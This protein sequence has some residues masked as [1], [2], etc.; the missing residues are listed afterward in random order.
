MRVVVRY[1]RLGDVYIFLFWK[2][3]IYTIS[4]SLTGAGR[5]IRDRCVY[6]SVCVCVCMCVC[7]CVCFIFYIDRIV[8]AIHFKPIKVFIIK[9]YLINI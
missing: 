2:E 7:V 4:I 5:G 9:L 1:R 3:M 8:A 6:V